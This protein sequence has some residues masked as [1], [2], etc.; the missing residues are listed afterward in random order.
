MRRLFRSRPSRLSS[1]T[2]AFLPCFAFLAASNIA[3]AQFKVTGPAPYSN[4]VAREK[5]KTLLASVDSNNSKPTADTLTGLLAWY[6]DI[7]D[8]ELIAAWQG[9]RRANLPEVIKPLADARVAAA[10]VDFSWRQ[11]RPVAFLSA[12]APMF[13]DL[14][15]R[16]PD[17]AKPVLGDLQQ[18]LELSA[19]EQQT[20]CRILIDM[21]DVGSWQKTAQ[22]ILP[23]YRQTAERL[24][25]QDLQ[26]GD[27]KKRDRAQ[28][29]MFDLRSSM[30]DS[31]ASATITSTSSSGRRRMPTD[32][33]P[34][35]IG[36]GSQP[37]AA[38]N[39]APTSA[40]TARPANPPPS[41]PANATAL[42]PGVPPAAPVHTAPTSGT[43]ECTGS[44]IPQNAEYVF[45]NLP[46]GKIQLDY[47][48]KIWDAR[49][50]PGEG[51]TQRLILKNK[52]SGAQKRCV[53]HWTA[54]Q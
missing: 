12:Y 26:S 22:Q 43:L 48:T 17:S 9:D 11:Q 32:D 7:I 54:S 3:H 51:P 19:S 25:A 28:Y 42:A 30:R 14:M 39:P 21:P 5:I 52:A 49:L 31:S 27:E 40:P 44:P 34:T 35:L 4:A 33:P 15:I 6:R 41:A 13:E 16:F 47:D 18:P 20:V 24:L 37:M 29:W 23:R 53:V 10:T 46:P 45:R 8:D 1:C 50:A 38:N 36:L 2:R